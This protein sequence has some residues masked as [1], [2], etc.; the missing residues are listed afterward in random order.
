M[1]EL[2]ELAMY[3]IIELSNNPAG[4]VLREIERWTK[5]II[6]NRKKS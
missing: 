6:N 2:E 3:H 5:A 1:N 4:S